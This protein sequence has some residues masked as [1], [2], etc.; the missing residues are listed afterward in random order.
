MERLVGNAQG[1]AAVEG[2]ITLPGGLREEARVLSAGAM[3]VLEN[4]EAQQDKVILEGRVVFH[5]LYTQGDPDKPQAMEASADF[6]H[7]LDL[8][9]AQARMLCRGDAAVEHVEATAYSGRLGLRA[10]L[11][12]RCRVLSTQP[13]AALTG[14]TG[15]EGLEQRTCT[16]SLKRTVAQGQAEALLREEYDLPAGLQITQT[17]YG[18]AIPRVTEITGGLG[19]AGVSGTVALRSTTPPILPASPCASPGTPCP[20]TRRWS[21]PARMGSSWTAG[22]WSRTWPWSA[23]KAPR[24][25][26]PCGWRCSWASPPGP[27]AGR[28]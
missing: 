16:L 14:I 19:R 15:V 10:I 13:V 21:S 5:A 27:T 4:V 24:A 6:T 26:V 7:T 17:L 23:R 9:G 22:R 8:P 18:T 1:Q 28:M 20:L 25:S 11:Q 2:E 12:T 3:V